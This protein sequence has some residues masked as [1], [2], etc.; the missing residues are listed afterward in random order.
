VRGSSAAGTPVQRLRHALDVLVRELVKFGLIGLVAFVVD[1]GGYNLLVFGPHVSS[2]LGDEATRGPLHDIPLRAKIL[3]V[4]VATLVSWLGNRYWTFRRRRRPAVAHELLL[5]VLFNLVGML[6]AV[7]C[8]GFSRYVLDL[9]TQLADNVSGNGVGL[10]LGTVF[11]F[12]AYRTVVFRGDA[13]ADS[14]RLPGS[15]VERPDA[16][17]AGDEPRTGITGAPRT[18]TARRSPAEP[19]P[20]PAGRR[21]PRRGRGRVRG[22]GRYSRRC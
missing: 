2:L 14:P 13:L 21:W 22:R 8:L 6:I 3:S 12:W 7:A 10:V 20:A 18:G 19:A 5:F 4:S 17:P 11:R 9:H 16:G 1:V 15:T